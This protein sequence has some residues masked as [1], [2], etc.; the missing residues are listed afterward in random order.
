MS[1]K[2]VYKITFPN[3]KI[4]IGQDVTDSVHYYG[5]P[6]RTAVEMDYPREK[7]RDMTIRKEILWES[8]TAS[9]EEVTRMEVALILQFRSNEPDIGY[10]Q[11]PDFSPSRF[12]SQ[13]SI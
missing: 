4:Y 1:F 2:V 5:S 3:G 11:K 13:D 6:S 8:E 9:D 10:N 12:G 7:R